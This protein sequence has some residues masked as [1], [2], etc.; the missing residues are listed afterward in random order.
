MFNY[1]LLHLETPRISCKYIVSSESST[2]LVAVSKIS[3][4]VFLGSLLIAVS[5]LST[6]TNRVISLQLFKRG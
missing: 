1:V 3:Y 5:L 4:C 2:V 6:Q